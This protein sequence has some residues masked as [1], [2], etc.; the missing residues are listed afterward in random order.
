[1]KSRVKVDEAFID[2][3]MYWCTDN[4][5][6]IGSGNIFVLCGRGP[7]LVHHPTNRHYY[8]DGRLNTLGT[9]YDRAGRVLLRMTEDGLKYNENKTVRTG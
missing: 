9:V 7:S 4:S 1:M 8:T 3:D 6:F 5:V 2:Q